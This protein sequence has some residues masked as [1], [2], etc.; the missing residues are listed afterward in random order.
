MGLMAMLLP[1]LAIL[2]AFCIN[3]AQMQLT[4]TE[5]MVSTDA[6]ARSGGRTMSETQSV[7]DAVLAARDTAAL[8]YVGGAPLQIRTGDGDAEIEFGITAQANHDARYTFVQVPTASIRNNGV[9][10]S[11]LRVTGR[12]NDGSLSG[13]LNLAIPGLLGVDTFQTDY[14]SV[15]MQVDRDISLVLDRSGSMR[16]P[17][18]SFPSNINPYNI[19]AY[20]AA[21]NAG[22]LRL[23]W[24]GFYPPWGS[25]WDDY[26]AWAYEEYYGLGPAQ[27]L[28][29]S[30]EVAVDAFL[31]V[32]DQTAQEEQVSLASYATSGSL[33]SFLEKDFD[34]VRNHVDQLFPDGATAIGEGMQQGITAI[35]HAN[36]RP[37]AAKTM[38]VLTDGRHNQGIHPEAAA[39]QLVAQSGLTIHT[40]TFGA[41]ADQQTMRDVASIGG[42]KHYH[43]ADGNALI[44]IFEEIAN[45]LPTILVQ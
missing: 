26:E 14:Q 44:E 33:H 22:V 21:F 37:Y 12:R 11:A 1:V 39:R 15:A 36:A 23:G 35:T 30:L 31:D 42:G 16:D 7:D 13:A 27:T 2:A 29:E 5:L 19:N 28:W 25:S 38:V 41:G 17:D 43:A 9:F 45:N 6:A 8:N 18:W 24:G 20:W 34:I 10:A 32:L 40:V 3:A 4:R